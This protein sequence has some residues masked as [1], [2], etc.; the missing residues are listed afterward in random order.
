MQLSK[1]WETWKKLKKKKIEKWK[2]DAL[3]DATNTESSGFES[4]Q[5]P[6]LFSLRISSA[7]RAT[8]SAWK[9][10]SNDISIE[11]LFAHRDCVQGPGAARST[12]AGKECDASRL[13]GSIESRPPSIRLPLQSQRQL[14]PSIG[15]HR[16]NASVSVSHFS[17]LKE[18][19]TGNGRFWTRVGHAM[20]TFEMHW[21]KHG[22]MMN[23]SNIPTFLCCFSHAG[24]SNPSL[25]HSSSCSM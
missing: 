13:A 6:I 8:D 10:P 16:R 9:T 18:S 3:R 20:A 22:L 24:S 14:H 1:T 2:R 4:R 12:W 17:L 23:M 21:I 7:G 5:R 15:R 11:F 25:S 19:E